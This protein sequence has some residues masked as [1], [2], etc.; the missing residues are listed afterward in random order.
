MGS[1][2]DIT[3]IAARQPWFLSMQWFLAIR[4]IAI[5]QCLFEDMYYILLNKGF[6]HSMVIV[7]SSPPPR[8]WRL[9]TAVV[10]TTSGGNGID[11]FDKG[12]HSLNIMSLEFLHDFK[13][14]DE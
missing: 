11:I 3:R 10:S 2:S 8:P 9:S 14:E 13:E 4:Y 12:F 5:C 7:F 1:T 6:N